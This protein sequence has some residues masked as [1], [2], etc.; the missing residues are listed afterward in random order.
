ML[1]IVKN[2]LQ[3]NELHQNGVVQG[4][5]YERTGSCHQCGQ[6]CTNIYLIYGKHTIDSLEMFETIKA[7]HPE[8][9]YF[10][11]RETNGNEIIFDC[12]N[13]QPDNRCAIYE[14]RPSF[15][16]IYPSEYSLKMGGK[17]AEGCG[18]QFKLRKT[19]SD[20]LKKMT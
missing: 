9:R 8:Y 6:C 19:F 17:L 18:Y 7:R 13:L 1:D 14:N 5:Y 20:I 3:P 16:K 15:C 2:F 10:T 12:V 4:K 11:P